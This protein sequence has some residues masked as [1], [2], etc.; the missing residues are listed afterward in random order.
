MVQMK[1][2]NLDLKSPGTSTAGP[3]IS[4][5]IPMEMD[6]SSQPLITHALF[7]SST[8]THEVSAIFPPTPVTVAST[9]GDLP[10]KHPSLKGHILELPEQDVHPS[11]TPTRGP[12]EPEELTSPARIGCFT[13]RPGGRPGAVRLYRLRLGTQC[14]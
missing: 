7:P 9:Q 10:R 11:M 6:T 5:P 13:S 1:K 2:E 4:S 3:M 12:S 14:R 8:T